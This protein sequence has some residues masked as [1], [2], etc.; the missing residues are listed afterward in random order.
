M[1]CCFCQS[2]V[3]DLLTIHFEYDGFAFS[4]CNNFQSDLLCAVCAKKNHIEKFEKHGR[5]IISKKDDEIQVEWN[6]CY[7][8]KEEETSARNS[9]LL[10]LGILSNDPR[11]NWVLLERGYPRTPIYWHKRCYFTR[12][13]DAIEYHRALYGRVIKR[14]MW[15][16]NEIHPL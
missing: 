5:S 16:I 14:E 6:I 4:V 13:E 15:N 1:S 2:P 12:K 10:S 3:D 7:Y 8:G 9:I 11:G